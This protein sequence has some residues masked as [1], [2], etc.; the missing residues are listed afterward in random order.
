MVH[1]NHSLCVFRKL[2]NDPV[3]GSNIAIV[4]VLVRSYSRLCL[5]I[6]LTCSPDPAI[7][8]LTNLEVFA[9]TL[10]ISSCLQQGRWNCKIWTVMKAQCFENEEYPKLSHA[11]HVECMTWCCQWVAVW[12][13]LLLFRTRTFTTCQCRHLLKMNWH[14]GP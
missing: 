2:C 12:F 3:S 8:S 9:M 11:M 6:H 10:P 7:G 13:L 14:R 4:D 1:K 5:L